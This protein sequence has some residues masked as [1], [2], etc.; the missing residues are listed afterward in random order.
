VSSAML[1]RARG[2]LEPL[3]SSARDTF[4]CV[5]A[6]V[7][8]SA[9]KTV[10]RAEMS[11][12]A[13]AEARTAA[14]ADD[15]DDAAAQDE[16]TEVYANGVAFSRAAS[17]LGAS[18]SL[19]HETFAALETSEHVQTIGYR[20]PRLGL[21]ATHKKRAVEAHNAAT[22]KALTKSV[23]RQQYALERKAREEALAAEESDSDSEDDRSKALERGKK[24]RGVYGRDAPSKKKKQKK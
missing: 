18:A 23:A 9:A 13:R 8:E 11:V 22:H 7:A 24:S 1:C 4:A 16:D 17:W 6:T 15:D 19:T 10:E 21:G 2:A 12:F 14:A 20:T 3:H 5:D